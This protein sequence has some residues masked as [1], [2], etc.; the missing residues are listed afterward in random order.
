MFNE[1]LDVSTGVRLSSSHLAKWQR[2]ADALGTN[3]NRVIALLIEAAEEPEPRPALVVGKINSRNASVSQAK[4]VAA[5][6][7]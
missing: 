1:K 2:L 5:V 7:A 3:R 4:G 6:S